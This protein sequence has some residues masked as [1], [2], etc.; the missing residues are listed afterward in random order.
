MQTIA[1]GMDK[2][3]DPAVEHSELY[4]VTCDGTWWRKMWEKEYIHMYIYIYVCVWLSHF[5]VQ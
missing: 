5:A 1:C 2:Q 4:Q 3:Q